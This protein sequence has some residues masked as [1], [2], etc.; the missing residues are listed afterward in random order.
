VAAIRAGQLGIPTMLVEG[1]PARR[2]LPER[3]L[4]PVQGADP[5]GRGIRAGLPLH[6]RHSPLGI[7][8]D[9]PVLDLAQ[10][11]QWKDGIVG[12][13]TGGVGA[14]LKK[15]GVQV[16]Q[17]W[18]RDLDGKTVD[19]ATREGE[20]VRI[21][22]STCCWPPARKAVELPLPA[23]RRP[24]HLLHRGAGAESV[25]KHLVVVGAGYIGLELGIAWRKLGAEVASWKRPAACC[26][27]TTTNSPAGAG[28]LRKLG[29]T[30]HLNCSVQGLTEHRR[31]RARAQQPGRRVRAAGRQGAG[32]GRPRAAHQPASGLEACSWT[33]P[34]AP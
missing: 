5:P 28:A 20:P 8:V 25:P 26:R 18:G 15:N 11:Q 2:H 29:I 4:H 24:R 22:A 23:L 13:L 10:A 6:R 21:R 1:E 7:R 27:P 9:N 3:G 19:V 16:V 14:L 34:A 31:R 17:G 30:L 32:G 12:K 33:W